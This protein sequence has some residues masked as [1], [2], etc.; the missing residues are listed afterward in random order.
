MAACTPDGP[1]TAPAD[2]GPT[3]TADSIVPGDR[4]EADEAL[5]AVE[6]LL[7]AD[8][9]EFFSRGYSPEAALIEISDEGF[10]EVVLN[11]DGSILLR[12][13]PLR[14]E[15]LMT[16]RRAALARYLE[17]LPGPELGIVRVEVNGDL[18][19]LRVFVD[20]AAASP[21]ALEML[22]FLDAALVLIVGLPR[23]LEGVHP[24]ELELRV[25][26]VDASTG[27]ALAVVRRAAG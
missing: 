27:E 8:F 2:P 17:E 9:V 1:H 22:G 18:T 15:R 12:M 6:I 7:P 23:I 20:T 5:P 10:D 21:E 11:P 3:P 13:S 19:E 14:H 16:E 4:S 25:D 26:Y 24:E